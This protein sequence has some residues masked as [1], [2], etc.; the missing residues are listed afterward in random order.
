MN[1]KVNLSDVILNR[2]LIPTTSVKSTVN[3][4]GIRT[5]IKEEIIE[6][7]V[8]VIVEVPAT[9]HPYTLLVEFGGTSNYISFQV[10]EKHGVWH[11]SNLINI[12]SYLVKIGQGNWQV[13]P[14]S[15]LVE[16]SDFVE[17]RVVK[18]NLNENAS[19]TIQGDY[20]LILDYVESSGSPIAFVDNWMMSMLESYQSIH[21]NM[22]DTPEFI[23]R[24]LEIHQPNYLIQDDLGN[25]FVGEIYNT[26]GPPG[27]NKAICD[28]LII[29]R[30]LKPT[31]NFA[32]NG[33][34]HLLY[35]SGSY[36]Q[37]LYLDNY[38]VF[39]RHQYANVTG[40]P[41]GK[42]IEFNDKGYWV[43]IAPTVRT[44][45]YFTTNLLDCKY[46]NF[47]FT[48][49]RSRPFVQYAHIYQTENIIEVQA[50][51]QPLIYN[52]KMISG[53]RMPRVQVFGG[54]TQTLARVADFYQNGIE[55]IDYFGFFS[56]AYSRYGFYGNA[57][58]R[59]SIDLFF[60]EMWKFY[61]VTPPITN[62]QVRFDLGKNETPTN[63][64]N[65]QHILL[66]NAI[67][68][69]AGYSLTININ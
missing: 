20:F 26:Y 18:N 5:V 2:A 49:Y 56:R 23:N 15:I 10:G 21:D 16:S 57:I 64:V 43:C 52:N 67:F 22:L 54:T 41:T 50:N 68:A 7:P 27:L 34:Y 55:E 33:L 59:A 14:V 8:E 47:A 42:P 60:E 9:N 62:C 25:T 31:T 19:V 61:S 38:G 66:L 44:F 63:G 69:S 29:C 1:I 39:K 36:S 40:L 51:E 6:V 58:K 46:P 37:T 48:G 65:N 24:F 17:I 3:A 45:I 53:R 32:L 12:G 11:F 13:N 4:Q 28:Y 30:L 35:P